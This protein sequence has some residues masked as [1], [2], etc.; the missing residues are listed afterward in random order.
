M[1]TETELLDRAVTCVEPQE[2]LSIFRERIY[3]ESLLHLSPGAT[4]YYASLQQPTPQFVDVS[5]N[6]IVQFSTSSMEHVLRDKVNAWNNYADHADR[7]LVSSPSV[8]GANSLFSWSTS[9]TSIAARKRILQERTSTASLNGTASIPESR[10]VLPLPPKNKPVMPRLARI[11]EKESSRFIQDRIEVI[12]AHHRQ[13]ASKKLDERKRKDHEMHLQR[14][15][16]KEAQFEQ[17]LKKA[18]A[19]QSMN[20]LTGFFGSLFGTSKQS[21][22]SFTLDF[23]SEVQSYPAPVAPTATP[24]KVRP[25]SL[26]AGFLKPLSLRTASPQSTRAEVSFEDTRS[27]IDTNSAQIQGL[28]ALEAGEAKRNSANGE[29]PHESLPSPAPP[30]IKENDD[31]LVL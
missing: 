22:S 20:R 18:I 24:P 9:D 19:M 27:S 21:S 30:V 31:L 4:K 5:E 16:R 25:K 6:S 28:D 23:D 26:L 3:P 12:K 15:Q 8:S 10:P 2:P 7:D 17:S 29:N 13:E 11:V 1:Q 14:I